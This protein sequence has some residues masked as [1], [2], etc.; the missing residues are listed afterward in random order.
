MLA[1][2]DA[3]ITVELPDG[4]SLEIDRG[5]AI[6]L[7]ERLGGRSGDAARTAAA[8]LTDAALAGG[9]GVVELDPDG[10]D[11]VLAQL[12]QM[13]VDRELEGTLPDLLRFVGG[14]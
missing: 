5:D 11:A 4:R 2:V 12:L 10:A 7:A 1:L 9:G 14:A 6:L 8:G 13:D 3:G